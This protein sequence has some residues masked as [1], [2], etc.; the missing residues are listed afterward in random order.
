MTEYDVKKLIK[1]A[2]EEER[3]SM[4]ALVAAVKATRVLLSGEYGYEDGPPDAEAMFQELS[5]LIAMKDK[6]FVFRAHHHNGG[7]TED[8]VWARTELHAK[9]LGAMIHKD[10]F[11]SDV[12]LKT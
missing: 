12:R 11:I 3:Q 10:R 1:E 6:V 9:A 2:L 8:E 7:Y 4:A 5:E